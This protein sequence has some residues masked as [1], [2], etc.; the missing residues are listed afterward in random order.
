MTKYSK[1]IKQEVAE[2][3]KA[4]EKNRDCAELLDYIE[5]SIEELNDIIKNPEELDIFKFKNQHNYE[6]LLNYDLKKELEKIAKNKDKI[7]SIEK[8][9][10][11]IKTR[12]T[13]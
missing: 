9:N 10:E 13:R 8:E 4:L 5:Y 3:K 1:I 11:I 2:S 7:K 12:G 6:F